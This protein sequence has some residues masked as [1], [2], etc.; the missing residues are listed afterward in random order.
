[1]KILNRANASKLASKQDTFLFLVVLL[2]GFFVILTFNV[3]DEFADPGEVEDILVRIVL[4]C[5]LLVI[6]ALIL[7]FVPLFKLSSEQAGDNCY[8]L[9]FVFTLISLA[10]A[11]YDFADVNAR[12]TIER[13]IVVQDFGI[14]LATTIVGLVLRVLFNQARL[15]PDHIEVATR[16]ALTES[17]RNMRDELDRVVIDFNHFKRHLQQSLNDTSYENQEIVQRTHLQL[18]EKYEE[19]SNKLVSQIEES[20]EKFSV[21]HTQVSEQ[22]LKISENLSENIGELNE[23]FRVL[24]SRFSEGYKEILQ[25]LSK[26]GDSIDKSSVNFEKFNKEFDELHQSLL[27]SSTETVQVIEKTLENMNATLQ[28]IDRPRIESEKLAHS[29]ETLN[30]QLTQL[31]EALDQAKIEELFSFLSKIKQAREEL[32]SEKEP[33]DNSISTVNKLTEELTSLHSAL[34]ELTNSV[35]RS[36]IK[37]K[38]RKSRLF[39]RTKSK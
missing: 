26:H 29:I 27:T 17:A 35:K 11:L 38:G 20:D 1:M 32:I 19:I 8:Y 5:L 2:L 25:S 15:D 23:A 37:G 30:G 16:E 4:P 22:H 14:A 10:F 6:Y 3:V 13:A 18:S 24:H 39:F 34:V 31:N 9:G 28:S 7:W 21:L 33:L 12:T 36:E